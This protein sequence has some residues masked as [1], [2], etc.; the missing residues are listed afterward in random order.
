MVK[1]REFDNPDEGAP[2]CASAPD[3]WFPEPGDR[4]GDRRLALKI[5]GRCRFQRACNAAAADG[6]ERH[7]IWGGRT[8]SDREQER[9]RKRREGR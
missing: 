7:G 4:G 6:D 8:R 1:R 2:P 9:K 3:L 5:C